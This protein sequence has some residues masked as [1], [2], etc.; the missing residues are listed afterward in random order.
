MKN[1]EEKKTRPKYKGQIYTKDTK[2]K[3][4]KKE[5]KSELC[6]GINDR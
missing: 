3:R 2:K 4:R 5:K 6:L 1:R